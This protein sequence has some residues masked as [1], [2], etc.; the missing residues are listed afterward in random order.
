[1]NIWLRIRRLNLMQ[2]IQF[3]SLFMT[4]PLLI[5][6]T[7]KASK[8]TMM[9]CDKHFGK[10]HHKSNRANAFRHAFWNYL[11]CQKTLKRTK[12]VE[13]STVWAK[14][15]TFLYEKATQNK[16]LEKVMDLHNNEIGRN[17]FLD[18][19]DQK[20]PKIIEILQEMMKN[21]QKIVKTEEV[22]NYKQQLVFI[23]D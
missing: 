17:L 8:R 20:E 23:E 11:I 9:V 5:V 3:V 15:V 4:R 18:V 6:P 22:L 13:K 14:K 19:F 2:F 7:F 21:A 16:N 10:S 1:M 12:N